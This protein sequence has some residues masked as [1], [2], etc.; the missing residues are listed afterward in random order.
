MNL[1]RLNVSIFM[2]LFCVY[3][4]F[5][6]FHINNKK[7][8]AVIWNR[9]VMLMIDHCDYNR[10]PDHS[11]WRKREFRLEN[12][13]PKPWTRPKDP[14]VRAI[15][16]TPLKCM[17]CNSAFSTILFN[18]IY[19]FIVFYHCRKHEFRAH[20]SNFHVFIQLRRLREKRLVTCAG[21][22]GRGR[23]Q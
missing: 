5:L 13:N 7:I 20:D 10:C 9:D 1:C 6:C 18:F 21:V 23:C 16:S 17:S 12:G 22:S 19:L 2:Q 15:L 4:Y 3:G 8:G 14:P 11:L